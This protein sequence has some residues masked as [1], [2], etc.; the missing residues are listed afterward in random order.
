MKDLSGLVL[1]SVGFWLGGLTYFVV[2]IME[3][4]KQQKEAIL[5]LNEVL[6]LLRK[7]RGC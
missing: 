4:L 7:A 1:V 6:K 2:V 5:Q 3:C